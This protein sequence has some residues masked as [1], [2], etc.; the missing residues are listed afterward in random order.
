MNSFVNIVKSKICIVCL[1]VLYD[2]NHYS[3][4]NANNKMRAERIYNKLYE[5][6]KIMLRYYSKKSNSKNFFK[7]WKNKADYYKRIETIKRELSTNVQDELKRRVEELEKILVEKVKEYEVLKE[8]YNKSVKNEK[9]L[10][11]I[12][13][14]FETMNEENIF[15][16]SKLEVYIIII[17]MKIFY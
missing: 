15:K 13:K 1:G 6:I 11:D 4:R 5:A 9:Q 8:S 10:I 7:I 3:E 17:R 14:S 12:L 16:I 2:I